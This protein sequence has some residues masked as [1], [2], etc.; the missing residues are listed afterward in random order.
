MPFLAPRPRYP[1]LHAPGGGADSFRFDGP[2]PPSE[3][4][5]RDRTVAIIDRLR[6]DRLLA[7]PRQDLTEEGGAG[8]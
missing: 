6:R 2:I 5:L 4:E 3:R 8:S 1:S 7:T